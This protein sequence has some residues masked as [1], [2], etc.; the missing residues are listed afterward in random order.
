LLTKNHIFEQFAND[1]ELLKYIPTG[2]K[3]SSLTRELLLS[4]LAYI[5]KDKYLRLYQIYKSTKL[6]RST[7][8]CKKYDIQIQGNFVENIQNYVSVNK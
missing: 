7:T 4:I 2:A 6:Q 8:G 3:V 1:A 5:R